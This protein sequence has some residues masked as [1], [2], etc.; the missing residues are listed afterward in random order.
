MTDPRTSEIL[1][2]IAANSGVDRAKLQ[3]DTTLDELGITSLKLIEAVFDIE[4]KYDIEIS[5]DGILMTPD[6]T[7]GS[8]IQRVLDTIDAA[9]AKGTAA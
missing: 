1:D 2:I 9:K 7:L 5:T 4:T 3:L 8:L 6:I